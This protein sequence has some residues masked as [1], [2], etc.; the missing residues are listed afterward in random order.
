MTSLE[1]CPAAWI[2]KFLRQ[3]GKPTYGTYGF[4]RP[5]W[6]RLSLAFDMSSTDLQT[7]FAGNG[8]SQ[9]RSLIED[10]GHPSGGFGFIEIATKEEGA[11]AIEK[12]NGSQLRGRA[13]KVNSAK[14]RGREDFQLEMEHSLSDYVSNPHRAKN[15]NSRLM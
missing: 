10:P 5:A 8:H 3:I 4:C 11:V 14:P 13:L 9:K 7:M 12:F 1:R 15:R 6:G 2:C